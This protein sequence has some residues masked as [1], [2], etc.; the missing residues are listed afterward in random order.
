MVRGLDI[1]QERFAAYVEQY[2]LISGT[3]AT[4]TMEE[5]GMEFRATKD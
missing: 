1:F 2:V 3:V 4:L 5:V